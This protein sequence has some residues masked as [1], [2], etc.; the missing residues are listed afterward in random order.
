[1]CNKR[2]KTA[3]MSMAAT[4]GQDN[5]I[6][7]ESS[8]KGKIK[9]F[10]KKNINNTLD[11]N[12]F[13]N[14]C[15]PQISSLLS[16]MASIHPIKYN[17]KL[18]ATYSIP[19][20]ENTTENRA[21]KTSA[22][23]LYSASDLNAAVLDDFTK[24]LEEEDEYVAKGSGYSLQTIDGILLGVYVFTPLRASSHIYLPEDIIR[25]KAVIN[26][27]NLKDNECF[28]WA[29]LAKHVSSGN[30]NHV[31]ENYKKLEKMYNFN[32]IIYP[33]PL[34]NIKIFEIDNP[35]VSINVYGLEKQP[36]HTKFKPAHYVYPLRVSNSE[37][38]DHFDLLVIEDE[39]TGLS[40]FTYISNFARLIHSQKTKNHSKMVF[41]KKCFTG[42]DTRPKLHK[43]SGQEALDQHRQICN[44]HKT[45]LPVMPEAG[46]TLKFEAWGKTV[47]HPFVVYADFEALLIKPNNSGSKGGNTKIIDEHK[48]MS[49]GFYVKAADNIPIEL[50]K[51]YNIP[52]TPICFRGSQTIDSAEVAKRF[53]EALVEV[54]TNI[55]ALLQTNTA[56]RFTD[57]EAQ[58]HAAAISCEICRCSFTDSNQKLL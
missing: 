26:P 45:I 10:Y 21:F 54:A 55:S 30:K 9:W 56:I 6:H 19:Q 29:I 40:H 18:E 25:K 39:T 8:F 28:K 7:I 5:F 2:K 33:T 32:R 22:R 47:R 15:K 34:K 20:Q 44:K 31:G 48:L 13:L 36:G 57:E 12:E 43:L 49:Y 4:A 11:Y 16:S 35:A 51:R 17:L 41:C 23:E 37:K 52:L 1:M 46:S 24:L 53:V 58:R 50:L 3:R 38:I 27:M 14:N 42:F